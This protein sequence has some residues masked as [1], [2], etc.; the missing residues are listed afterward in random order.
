MGWRAHRQN[1]NLVAILVFIFFT[2]VYLRGGSSSDDGTYTQ[3]PHH[4]HGPLA[5][6]EQDKPKQGL[7]DDDVEMVV[8]SM[9]KENITW[10]NDYLLNWKKNIYV[11][12]D[13]SAALT[14]P[15]NKGREA[16][17]FL[18]YI[19]DRYDTLPGNV[20]FHHAERFQW[21]NDNLDYDALPLLQ[22]FRLE[23]LKK[24]GYVNLR[25]VWVLGCPAE[26]R[27]TLDES[28]PVK[29]EPVHA[30]HVYKAG[31]QQLF[32]EIPVPDIV[33]VTCCSQFAVRRE[34]IHKRPKSDYVRYR[35]WLV[36][37][38]LGDDLSGRVL[39]YSWHI[40]F[41]KKS[42]HCPHAGECYCNMY[43]MCDMKCE[44]DKCENQYILPPFAT[45][46]KGWP[47]LDTHNRLVADVLTRYRTLMMLA[48]IQAEGERNNANPETIAVTGISMKLE[49]DGLYSSI[50]ELLTLSRK[51]KEL[52]VFGPLGRDDPDR[53]AKELRIDEDVSRVAE[54]LAAME[55]RGM[56]GLA[57]GLGGE[58][59]VLGGNAD[60]AARAA[61]AAGN[62]PR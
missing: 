3:S 7:G 26:I 32:P 44:T 40:M 47:Q 39:E 12:D 41:G 48:T 28:P 23:H 22:R 45:L 14:V 27:P 6:V 8:A 34:T 61:A 54:L 35:D 53:K 56:G 29:N 18:T 9:K 1:V 62:P 50:K 52:W 11:V 55:A 19:I 17:V 37:S 5:E 31:F 38:S 33:G 43:G 21:H 42:I 2:V 15:Q 13:P 59:E 60:E 24:E 20:I 49:F 16:M 25:C 58:W 51:I 46:P 4:P 30:K 10:L 57:K 36:G